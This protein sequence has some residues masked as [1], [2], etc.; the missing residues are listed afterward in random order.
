MQKPQSLVFLCNS[1]E[2]ITFIVKVGHLSKVLKNQ[3]YASP[4]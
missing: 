2:S 4:A 1:L 3:R